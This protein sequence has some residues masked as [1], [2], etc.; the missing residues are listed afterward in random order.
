MLASAYDPSALLGL[1]GPLLLAAGA[2]AAL[3]GITRQQIAKNWRES[4]EAFKSQSEAH[5]ASS[6]TYRLQVKE[7]AGQAQMT[8]A[9]ILELEK[10]IHRL[11]SLPNLAL[12]RKDLEKHHSVITAILARIEEQTKRR[13]EGGGA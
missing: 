6:E 12:L 5:K 11:S 3:W 9:R 13:P 10:E 7:Y 4:A 2:V 1:L 8:E